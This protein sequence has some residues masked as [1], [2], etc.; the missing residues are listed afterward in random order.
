VTGS[1]APG[2]QHE[3][4]STDAA[5]AWMFAAAAL[6]LGIGTVSVNLDVGTWLVVASAVLTA[7]GLFASSRL[8]VFNERSVRTVLSAGILV[9]VLVLAVAPAV[10][11]LRYSVGVAVLGA[12]A[13]HVLLVETRWR[14]AELVVVVAG[15]T[16]LM[17]WLLA[18]SGPPAIDVHQFQQEAAAALLQGS[19]P[20]ELRYENLSVPGSP[21]YSPEVEDGDRLTFGFVYPPLSLLMALPGYVLF[22]DY[23]YAA[24]AAIS[25][26]CLLMAFCRPGAPA[27][28][29]ALLVL[30]S[31]VIPRIVYWGW[32][33]PF[34]AVTLA[35][36]TFFAVR[37]SAATP[38]WLG[39]SIASKQYVFPIYLVGLAVLWTLRRRLGW[40]NLAIVPLAVAAVT[41]VPFLVWD[42]GSL[43]YS[44][45]TAH[46]LQPFRLDSLSLPAV[47]VRAGLP[48]PPTFIG[49]GAAAVAL[50]PVAAWAP[51]TPAAFAAGGVLVFAAFFL[52][53][54]QAHMNYYFLLIVGLGCAIA[55]A[56]VRRVAPTAG[57]A[58][59]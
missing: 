34:V 44:T 1:T 6:L 17:A 51:R 19:N 45:I 46:N 48:Q 16:G 57:V 11:D 9:E 28:G 43:I 20:Y 42:A 39:L 36:T 31:P 18:A 13:L 41:V 47:L 5:T 25:G 2:P 50:A 27:F 3:A 30:F 35:A 54:K 32:S 38:V 40:R 21:Y 22:G 7:A 23:R 24:L 59:T 55:A 58:A 33:E 52:F 8:R 56:S 49:F 26:A 12:I 53:G 15:Y 14:R 10:V 29:A 37:A 4:S